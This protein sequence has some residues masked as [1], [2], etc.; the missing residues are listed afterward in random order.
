MPPIVNELEQKYG[1]KL[2]VQRTEDYGPATKL[3][4]ALLVEK[5][6]ATVVVTV[7]DDVTYHPDTVLGN[8]A[9]ANCTR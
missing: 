6:P 2:V 7:D 4:G 9:R 5:D 1:K 3:L 8:R